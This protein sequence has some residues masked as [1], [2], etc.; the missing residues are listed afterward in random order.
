MTAITAE[1]ESPT[2]AI[3]GA[4][5]AG[6]AC[7]VELARHCVPVTVF[8]RSL[9]LGGRARVAGGA[10]AKTAQGKIDNG[11]H[12]VIG[13]YT[14]LARLLRLTGCSPRQFE[15]LPLT[16]HIPGRIRLKA[17]PLPAPFHLA[18]GLLFARGL[19]WRERLA[20]IRWLG[21]LKRARYRVAADMTVETLLSPLPPKLREH[22]WEPLC[23]AALNT[24]PPQASAQV[25]VNILRDSL[26]ANAAASEL[27][28]PRVDLS[29]LFPVPAARY[30]ATREGEVRTGNAISAITPVA[31]VANGGGG[32]FLEGDSTRRRW[33]QVVIATAP[34]H[35]APLLASMTGCENLAASL[36][37]LH[38]E[39]ITTV[40][41]AFGDGVSLPEPMIGFATPPAQ[42]AFDRGRCG[43]PA[44]LIAAVIS[45]HGEHL[46]REAQDRAALCGQICAQLENALGRTLP[47]PQWTQ[48]I[49]EKRATFACRPGIERPASATPVPGLWLT[50][51]YVANDYPATLEAAARNGVACARALLNRP[52]VSPVAAPPDAG[53]SP[54]TTG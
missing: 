24:P 32:F 48:V 54:S 12:L 46:A 27:L 2:V 53:N 13:A 38:H 52:D 4:G 49:T 18:A 6:L 35:A 41:L 25:F 50:G 29:E 26:G 34:H 1:T 20:M 15:R 31:P 44:G 33:S 47:A 21:Q 5:Y 7:A 28:I 43:G 42:W 8:E 39:P 10:G 30:L 22:I 14:E 11:Q 45:A 9:T 16:L 19:D 3:I 17:A 51:D 37:R 36:A 40:Y 23:L